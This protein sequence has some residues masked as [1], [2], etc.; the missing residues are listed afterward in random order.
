MHG[1]SGASCLVGAGAGALGS[2]VEAGGALAKTVTQRRRL[3][4]SAPSVL[5]DDSAI[6]AGLMDRAGR[7]RNP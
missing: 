7:L 2:V 5:T 4:T 3:P 1:R 6:R